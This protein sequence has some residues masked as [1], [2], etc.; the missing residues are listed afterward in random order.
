MPDT[1]LCSR[2]PPIS[3]SVVFSLITISTIRSLPRYIEA[4]PSTIT[5]MSQNAGMY[6]PPAADGPN[7]AQTCGIEPD[8]RTWEWKILPAPRRPGNISTWSVIR[9]PAE[10]TR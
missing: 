9:A 3:S 4:L 10:S 1:V 8:A 5:M 6:A 2:A 7:S